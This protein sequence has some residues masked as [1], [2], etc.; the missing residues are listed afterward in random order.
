MATEEWEA[1]CKRCGKCCYMLEEVDGKLKRH[2]TLACQY[3]D[4]ST[5]TCMVYENRF[6]INPNC[7]EI[8]KIRVNGWLNKRFIIVA[9]KHSDKYLALV[10]WDGRFSIYEQR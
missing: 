10:N 1:Q 6:M 2:D 5:N 4:K 3:L 7:R 8:I 9:A